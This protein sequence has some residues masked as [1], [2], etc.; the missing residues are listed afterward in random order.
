MLMNISQRNRNLGIWIWTRS[1]KFLLWTAISLGALGAILL[2]INAILI[3][4]TGAQLEKRIAALRA[5]GAPVTFGDL[6][7]PAVPPESNAAVYL[8][9]AEADVD[10]ITK[11]LAPVEGSPSFND[12]RLGEAEQ[13]A[14]QTVF[15]A[16][17]RFLR[18]LEKAA[19]CPSYNSETDF[20]AGPQA[21]MADVLLP[22]SSRFR[23]CMQVLS[24]RTHLL[25]SQGRFEEALQNCVVIFRL[26]RH[27]EHEPLLVNF[28]VGL[29]ARAIGVANAN[30][31]LRSGPVSAAARS[32]L[33]AELVRGDSHQSFQHAL[34]SERV[35]GLETSR[36]MAQCVFRAQLN[37]L[38][39]ALIDMFNHHL[40]LATQPYPIVAADKPQWESDHW[41]M[42][43]A[44]ARLAEQAI[45]KTRSVWERS[46][47]QVRCLRVLLALQE[48]SLR[49]QDREPR[50]T[51]LGLPVEAFTDPF[52]GAPLRLKK[53]DAGWIIYSVG[54]DRV[55]DGGNL[56]DDKDVG[57]GPVPGVSK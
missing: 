7:E 21:Y 48:E 5:V 15:D 11:E 38:Q 1:K 25:V 37:D 23:G 27:F 30:L 17:P 20:T 53:S 3:R 28:L 41:S 9:R 14:V 44:L 46:R 51:E 35:Y 18:D 49:S 19:A 55:D 56:T 57:L 34:V 6:A 26:T 43:N 4:I 10:A 52:S 45:L 39:C 47:A 22:Q 32:A 31:V 16:Y 42:S 50:I 36:D 12:G 24:D 33:A 29:S 8:R 2:V 13:K 40:E 54:V